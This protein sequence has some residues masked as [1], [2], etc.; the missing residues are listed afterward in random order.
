M[1]DPLVWK[2]IDGVRK[3][4]NIGAHMEQD[5]NIIV[6]VEPEEAERLTW[7]IEYLVDDWYVARHNRQ[8]GLA[9]IVEMANEKEIER[10]GKD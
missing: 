4:G 3:I 6:E 1:V 9:A 8:E 2:A 7:L 10:R 5:I